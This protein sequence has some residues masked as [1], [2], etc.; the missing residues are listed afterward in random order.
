MVHH[1]NWQFLKGIYFFLI[2]GSLFVIYKLFDK[3][4]YKK[5]ETSE[6]YH[7]FIEIFIDEESEHYDKDYLDQF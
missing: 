1:V 4:I 2:A 6:H 7:S 3:M 5:L